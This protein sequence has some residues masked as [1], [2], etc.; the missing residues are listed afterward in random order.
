M[1]IGSNI[2]QYSTI[3]G[4]VMIRFWFFL[5]DS[6]IFSKSS[7]VGYGSS[8]RFL[9]SNNSFAKGESVWHFW[10]GNVSI[11]PRNLARIL[12]SMIILSQSSF[13]SWS[14][15]LISFLASIERL[16]KSLRCVT[17][18]KV[19]C[20]IN[21]LKNSWLPEK[22]GS[23]QGPPNCDLVTILLNNLSELTLVFKEDRS[24]RSSES[25]AAIDKDAALAIN[26]PKK[27]V[28]KCL[29]LTGW[30]WRLSNLI[31]Q[32]PMS[33]FVLGDQCLSMS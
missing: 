30:L 29:R 28:A 6:K 9:I 26:C 25:S 16:S 8:S 18:P 13:S 11:K 23:G 2:E 12:N 10:Y 22:V 17:N 14:P 21:S 32:G 15:L 4:I 19:E 24:F 5:D 27:R 20:M 33:L 1:L 7:F 3:Q 31:T